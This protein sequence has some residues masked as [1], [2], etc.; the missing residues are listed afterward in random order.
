MSKKLMNVVLA[1]AL[2]A[3]ITGCSSTTTEEESTTTETAEEVSEVVEEVS[4]EA[5]S[6]LEMSVEE[7]EVDL[8]VLEEH[9]EVF[10]YTSEVK[11]DYSNVVQ[12]A[13]YVFAGNKSEEEAE[14]LV[15]E[16]GIGSVLNKWAGSVEVINPLDGTSYGAEDADN[17]L[18]LLGAGI[19]NAKVIG[20]DE[21]ATF[22]NNELRTNLYAVAGLMMYGGEMEE[23]VSEGVNVPCY[24]VNPAENAKS[25]FTAVN[26]VSSL[27]KTIVGEE[28]NLKDAFENAW[29]Q[30]F[31][32]N[33][34]QHNSKTE[35]YNIS[36]RDVTEDYELIE[37]ADLGALGI[38]Y[39]PHYDEAVNGEG[40][41]TWF[42]YIPTATLAKEDGSVPLVIS[43]HGNG[44]DARLHD[45]TPGWPE[46]AAKEEFM[47]IAPEWQQEVVEGGQTEGHPNFFEC[48]GLEGDK[49]IE[50]LN[51]VI[52]AKYPQI[53][54]TR[55]YLNGLSAG[56][57]ASTLYGVKY[58]DIFAAV[59]VVSGPGVDKVELASIAET[60]EGG[61]VPY[62]YICGDHDFFGMLPVDGSST[63]SFPI[64]P[65][66]GIYIQHVDPNVDMFP[67]I[68]SYQK[69]NGMEVSETYNMEDNEFYG[70][71]LDE[72]TWV[73]LGAKEALEGTLS[74]ENGV[75][76]KLLGVK[77]LAHWNY[78]AEAEYIWNF[79]SQFAR[80][81]D[82]TLKR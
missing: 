75:C 64:D 1:S 52:L 59:G 9:D 70:V 50:W 81:E 3:G 27:D 51:D 60:Y 30:V 67:F 32:K 41:Y 16:M 8:A 56:A 12:P 38:M 57:S 5:V 15:K 26:T 55:I 43:L 39:E 13:F 82:G 48:D 25:Y 80:N 35:F 34:R 7:V 18:D 36:A 21:G 66:N 31:S 23:E 73:T 62:V 46:L 24:L 63:N 33:Y 20:I 45:D 68:Q 2:L 42:E 53:D 14:S 69:I 22:V 28:D 78:K 79:I 19:C 29:N 37:I 40:K 4:N 76:I 65:D 72:Q 77:D 47:F 49:L 74:N 58:S 6:S 61:E 54:T 44:N 71:K 17:F 11:I 10:L